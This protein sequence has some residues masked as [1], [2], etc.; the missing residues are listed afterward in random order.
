VSDAPTLTPGFVLDDKWRI[1]R[2]LGVGGMGAVYAAEHVRTGSQVAV[3]VV[4]P[5][6]AKDAAA[7]DRFRIEGYAA[8]SVAHPGV[9]RVLD[10]GTT[11]EG[12]PYLVMERLEGAS[13]DG[14]ADRLGGR[15]PVDDVVRYMSAALEIVAAAHAK[16]IVHRDLKPENFFACKDGSVK[17]LDFGIA[18]VKEVVS[19]TRLTTTGVPMG[20]P[21]YMPAEQALARWNEVDARSD[22]WS[23]G[24]SFFSLLTGEIVHVGTTVPELLVAVSTTDARPVRSLAPQVPIPIAAVIDRALRR[25][26][27]ERFADAG[28]MLAALRAA[29]NGQTLDPLP[30][31]AP[32][33]ADGRSLHAFEPAA[34]RRTGSPVSTDASRREKRATSRAVGAVLGFA[35]VGSGVGVFAWKW[36]SPPA[37]GASLEPAPVEA[38]VARPSPISPDL[39]T[40]PAPT[41]TSP[42]PVDVSPAAPSGSAQALPSA[43]PSTVPDVPSSTP[44]AKPVALPRPTGTSKPGPTAKPTATAKP[45]VYD[46]FTRRCK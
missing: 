46:A 39:S 7:R 17:V 14:L 32:A 16:G 40:G 29:L 13:L 18:R 25:T 30:D 28:E 3:K 20:T 42:S 22:V 21:A 1:E 45:C 36:L 15:M 27:S 31:V 44:T 19:Q 4:H 2:V 37:A 34:L 26:R 38:P 5:D 35:L 10:D 41:V 9:V 43:A 6:V 33:V 8:N 24:A 12:L 11:A 23:L